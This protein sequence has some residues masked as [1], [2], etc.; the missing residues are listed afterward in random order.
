MQTLTLRLCCLFL[1]VIPSLGQAG[2]SRQHDLE[3]ALRAVDELEAQGAYEAAR[4]Q[5]Q[6]LVRHVSPTLGEDLVMRRCELW[7]RQAQP[8]ECRACYLSLVGHG[9]TT[10]E[11]IAQARYRAAAAALE[12]GETEAGRQELTLLVDD[13]PYTESARRA[14]VLARALHR[15][16][17]GYMGESEFLMQVA[18]R[19]AWV[20]EPGAH[21][22]ESLLARELLAEALVEVGRLRLQEGRDAEAAQRILDRAQPIA[23]GTVWEDDALVW[24]A[25]SLRPLGRSGEALSLYQQLIDSQKTSWFMGVYYSEYYDDALYE[26]GQTLEEM[27]RLPEAERAYAELFRRVPTSR[28]LDDAAFRL[29]TLTAARRRDAAPLNTFIRDYPASRHV[30]AARSA[31]TMMP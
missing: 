28:L 7:H 25:R 18:S 19:L 22:D 1:L 5:L 8:A 20:A 14:F 17:A 2:R 12:L 13:L 23:R 24:L 15:E 21:R 11:H 26:V 31:M 30:R 27:R 6:G 3:L 4:R 29:A 10:V 16:Q 9:L